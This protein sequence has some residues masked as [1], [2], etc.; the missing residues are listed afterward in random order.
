MKSEKQSGEP[1]QARALQM[2]QA[3]WKNVFVD[4]CVPHARRR[5]TFELGN[6]DALITYELDGLLMK[7]SGEADGDYCACRPRSSANIRLVVIDR[8]VTPEK[9]A[10]VDAFVQYL[11]T[12]E[13]QAA[14]VKYHF[15]I[16]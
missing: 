10:I 2:L 7:E 13:A 8:N 11:W 5:T 16:Q 9:R 6:G 14:F 15:F 4:A 1:D 12:E 3:V